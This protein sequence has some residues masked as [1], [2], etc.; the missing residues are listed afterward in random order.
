MPKARLTDEESADLEDDVKERRLTELGALDSDEGVAFD[1]WREAPALTPEP[2][3]DE[4]FS[5]GFVAAHSRGR[6]K[7]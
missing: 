6:K 1:D 4:P 7:S 2:I 3:R 5:L